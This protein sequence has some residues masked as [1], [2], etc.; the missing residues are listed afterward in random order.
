MATENLDYVFGSR[1]KLMQ[2]T[3]KRSFSRH[4]IGRFIATLI[5]WKFK[6]G[7]YDTQCGAKCFRASMMNELTSDDFKTDWF[8]DVELF[9]RIKKSYPLAKGKEIP[10]AN[11]S[12]PGK[13]RLTLL[14]FPAVFGDLFALM[15][16]YRSQK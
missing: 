8:F 10:L 6:L 2:A 1:I 13:S 14:H 5:D 3:I 12:D 11:W 15:N 16:N 7:I 4:L 9:L